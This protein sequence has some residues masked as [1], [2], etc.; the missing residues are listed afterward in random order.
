[1]ID[2]HYQAPDQNAETW[3]S[4]FYQFSYRGNDLREVE[5]A[6]RAQFRFLLHGSGHYSFANGF[7]TDAFPV[8]VIGPTTGPCI[9]SA[10]E[11]IAIFGW[12][13]LPGGWAA[14]MGN[15]AERWI[16]KAFDARN[17]FGDAIMEMRERLI[18]A[19]EP[20]Q[21]FA[22]ATD[23]VAE[24]YRDADTAP[25]A[26]TA[27]VDRW[28]A[29][30]IDPDVEQ[31]IAISK[32]SP[33]QLERLTKRYYGMPPKKLARKYRALRAANRLALGDSLNESELGLAFY[34]QSHLAR[35]VKQFTGLTPSQL[36]SG[37]SQLTKATISGRNALGDTVSPLVSKS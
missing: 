35:E 1:M 16:D 30:N 17:I 15:E 37:S 5:R 31:L 27:M 7:E 12:G 29:A 13:M 21:R 25:F 9:S 10:A 26:F 4:S 36:K 34:D 22:I 11:P 20:Q 19:S 23:A 6:D 28:L 2:L 14:L 24:I 32:I 3:V 33:R 18:A 8:T